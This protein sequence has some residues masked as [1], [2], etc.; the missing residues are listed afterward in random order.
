[1]KSETQEEASAKVREG[2]TTDS[3]FD[4]LYHDGRRVAS[5]LA[6]FDPSGSVTQ[7]SQGTAAER[8]KA[9]IQKLEGTASIPAVA[10][11]VMTSTD[12]V[13]NRRQDEIMRVYDPMWANARELLD[14]LDKRGMIQRDLA[15]ARLGQIVL[16]SGSLDIYDLKIMSGIWSLN[17][18]KKSIAAG[19]SQWPKLSKAVQSTP[20]GKRL[21]AEFDQAQKAAKDGMELFIEMAPSLPHSA[22]AVVQTIN[23][24]KLWCN[25]DPSGLSMSPSDILLKHGIAVPGEWVILG[26]LDAVP[27]P[28][29]MRNR[30]QTPDGQEMVVKVFETLAPIIRTFF[31]RP[32]TA[33]GITP[34][35]IFRETSA[36]T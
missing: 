8:V 28:V 20:A 24:E 30:P 15:N 4:F 1:M 10:K 19:Q 22:H 17:S 34:L 2:Q 6:Q 27:E 36:P 12:E 7:I 33:Y 13:R 18:I 29:E 35:L 23:E 32:E 16:A 9:D 21:K 14:L 5:F 31:G 25:I 11:G 3:V 26:I